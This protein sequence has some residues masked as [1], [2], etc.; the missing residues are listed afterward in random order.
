MEGRCS[1]GSERVGME[2]RGEASADNSQPKTGSRVARDGDVRP[3]K[4]CGDVMLWG[5]VVEGWGMVLSVVFWVAV[6][7]LCGSCVRG[8]RIIW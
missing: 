7:E 6:V 2:R 3:M 5:I 1:G 8:G 4:E